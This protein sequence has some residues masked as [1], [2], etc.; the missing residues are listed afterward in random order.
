MQ[1]RG[2]F[3]L[4][5]YCFIIYGL[6]MENYAAFCKI[7]GPKLKKVELSKDKRNY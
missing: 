2:G 6:K 3:V 5:G 1:R 7:G 4:E